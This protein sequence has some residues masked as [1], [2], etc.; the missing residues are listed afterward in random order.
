MLNLSKNTYGKSPAAL[1]LTLYL[2]EKGDAALNRKVARKLEIWRGTLKDIVM[3]HIRTDEILPSTFGRV[4]AMM[5]TAMRAGALQ[6]PDKLAQELVT[7][8]L[9]SELRTWKT[10][11]STTAKLQRK[12]ARC[13]EQGEPV[14]VL[15]VM[16]RAGEESD[17]ARVLRLRM[18]S[19]I[20]LANSGKKN[21][22]Y[23]CT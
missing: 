19:S 6:L 12:A 23:E 3:A 9:I 15:R 4:L 20:R 13:T 14:P 5:D 2:N 21:T 11:Y 18:R 17:E 10:R 22:L 7:N 16:P 8:I 1:Y